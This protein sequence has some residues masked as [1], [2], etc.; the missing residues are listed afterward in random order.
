[1]KFLD[2]GKKQ[3]LG[4]NLPETSFQECRLR[5]LLFWLSSNA[6]VILAAVAVF[7][8]LVVKFVQ[9]RNSTIEF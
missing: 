2:S 6:F 3:K 8:Y 9:E 7:I 4:S 1:L 5:F